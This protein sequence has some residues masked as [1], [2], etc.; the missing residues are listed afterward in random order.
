[1]TLQSIISVI[2]SKNKDKKILFSN[3]NDKR[4]LQAAKTLIQQWHS[5]VICG[6]LEDLE[7]LVMN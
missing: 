3:P 6:R 2:K 1:M 4:I 7:V 5:P